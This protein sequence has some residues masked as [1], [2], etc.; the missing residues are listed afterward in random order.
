MNRL[1]LLLFPFILFFSGCRHESII[2][3]GTVPVSYNKS[4]SNIIISNCTSTC[5]EHTGQGNRSFTLTDND[6][7]LDTNKLKNYIQS[8]SPS[9]SKFYTAITSLASP[10][11]PSGPMPEGDIIQIYTWIKEGANYSN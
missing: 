9:K 7:V 6:T 2:P 5:H 8:G 4:I 1:L 10:M 3:A 11:P